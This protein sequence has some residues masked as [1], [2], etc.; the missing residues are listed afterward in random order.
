[1]EEIMKKKL[2]LG[3][4]GLFLLS[5]VSSP[6]IAQDANEILKKMIDAMG[7][8]KVLESIRDTTLTGTW[9]M[10]QMGMSGNLTMYQKEPNKMRWDGEMQGMVITMA[11]DGATAWWL[12][13]QT[14]ARE[15][16]PEGQAD[17]FKRGAM[18][19]DTLLD[20]AKFGISFAYKGKETINNKDYFVLEET[21]SD[22]YK[23]T[24]YIDPETNLLYKAKSKSTGP[25]GTE[26]ESE[27][28][29]SDYRKID[30]VMT[31]HSITIIQGGQ[32][33]M[34]MTFTSVKFNAGLEDS[35]FK[36]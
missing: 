36:K 18:G 28:L 24:L 4:L 2:L 15:D 16:M 12:N 13:P 8:R 11:Y 26:V 14:G 1:M 5:L 9:E 23:T 22:G 17:S 21:Y 27:S 33:Y 30:G 25:S 10:T 19:N 7:G 29:M 34:R 6:G 20:P 35:L 31:A 3:F 32:E